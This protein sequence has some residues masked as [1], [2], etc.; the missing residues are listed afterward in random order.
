MLVTARRDDLAGRRQIDFQE[1][2][3]RDFVGLTN[4]TAL[5][6]HIA[7]HAARLGVRL[8]FRARL[9]D[10]DAICQMVAAD[11]ACRGAGSRRQALRADDA[12]HDDPDPRR[13]GQ[14]QTDDLRP[15]F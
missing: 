10:F 2:R 3:D 8:K 15:Q 7:R 1:V 9:R 6:I 13:L 5:Q 11:V 14:P 4:S 12:D